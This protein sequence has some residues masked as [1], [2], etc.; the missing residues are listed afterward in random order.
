MNIFSCDYEKKDV[1]DG[2]IYERSDGALRGTVEEVKTAPSVSG[3]ENK[4]KRAENLGHHPGR[5]EGIGTFP[6]LP[7]GG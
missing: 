1:V 2:R 7:V 6:S 3:E 5:K 4:K